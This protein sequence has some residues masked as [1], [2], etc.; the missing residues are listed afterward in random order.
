[1]FHVN[2]SPPGHQLEQNDPVAVHVG[3]NAQIPR[4]NIGWVQVAYSPGWRSGRR[5]SADCQSEIGEARMTA[6]V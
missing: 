2:R 6:G 4:E 1:M 5:Q 3:L